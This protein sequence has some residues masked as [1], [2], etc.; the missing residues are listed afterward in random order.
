MKYWWASYLDDRRVKLL[1]P[2]IHD[3]SVTPFNAWKKIRKDCEFIVFPSNTYNPQ[4]AQQEAIHI[5]NT[6][7][8]KED[9]L[10][11]NISRTSTP[12]IIKSNLSKSINEEATAASV[13]R[14]RKV[15]A[16]PTT[17]K[18]YEH[19]AG[20]ED[21]HREEFTKRLSELDSDKAKIRYNALGGY[22]V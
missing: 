22:M 5:W 16:D 6:P 11:T 10:Q 18:L 20:E 9:F 4:I 8:L 17:A 1:G 19:I 21:G 2:W 3:D 13:Y 15:T 12:Q 14:Q 7:E